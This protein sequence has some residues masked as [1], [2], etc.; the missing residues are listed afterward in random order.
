MRRMV[1]ELTGALHGPV[2][3]ADE[4]AFADLAPAGY[5][6]A[7][8]LGFAFPL[9]EYVAFP[10][11]WVD[12]Y[13][14]EGLMLDDP[15][16]RWAYDNTGAARWSESAAPIRAACWSGRGRMAFCTGRSW[17]A[18]GRAGR[19]A[20]AVSHAPTGRSPMRNWI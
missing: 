16:V 20:M 14:R 3:P 2:H 11:P 10:K 7:V 15:A 6:I 8:R 12:L 1:Q 18:T 4:E 19:G 5:Y 13:G 17:P 9:A